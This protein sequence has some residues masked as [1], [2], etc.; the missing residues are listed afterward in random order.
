MEDLIPI[1]RPSLGEEEQKAVIDVLNSG[2][3]A[4]GP[5]VEAF[6]S[7]MAEYC[8][9]SYAVATTSCTT[10]LHLALHALAVGPGDEVVV[11][12][13]SFIATANAPSYV[14]AKPVFADVDRSTQNLTA[15]TIE[16]ALTP[17][18][19]A[20]IIVHQAGMPADIDEIHGLLD[21]L[22]IPIIEDAA[23]AIGSTYKDNRIGAGRNIVCFS[24]H[25]RKLLTTGE[26]GM[27]LTSNQEF[28]NHF[29]RL[30][31]H[32]RNISA[33][34]SHTSTQNI[35][36]EEYLETGFNFRM[37]DLQA[38]IGIIQLEKIESI[39]SERRKL[40]ACY[41][42]ALSKIKTI[43]TPQ[44]PPYGKTNFQSFIVTLSDDIPTSPRKI[45]ASLLEKQISARRGI[46]ASHLEP[47]F[48]KYS[49]DF[50][51]LPNTEW[52]TN[53][54]IILPMYQGMSEVEIHRVVDALQ[55]AI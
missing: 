15:Q 20:V 21:P 22:G 14:G 51:S 36:I 1:I 11:P 16:K 3:I 42:K 18:T 48:K 41:E 9:S 13:L 26:G 35:L 53:H 55:A 47:A 52:L 38:A 17:K 8:G 28:A 24:F 45:L 25:P 5:R 30:R 44:D 54:S 19:R 37:T 4:Q 32:G 33:Y 23:C 27:I 7:A 39:I 43:S 34:A 10:A 29:L 31:D 40:A 6:E 50:L 12:S 46:M 49:S 2:W